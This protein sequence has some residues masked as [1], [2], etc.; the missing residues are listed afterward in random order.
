MKEKQQTKQKKVND[1]PNKKAIK[2]MNKILHKKKID[3]LEGL[4]SIINSQNNLENTS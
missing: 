2:K 4:E 1:K 3:E